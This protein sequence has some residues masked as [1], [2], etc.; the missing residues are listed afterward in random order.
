MLNVSGLPTQTIPLL[1]YVG[2]TVINA[3]SDTID[4]LVAV[5]LGISPVPLAAKPIEGLSLVQ[6]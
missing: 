5:K 4:G 2:V 1:S 3:P 6:L